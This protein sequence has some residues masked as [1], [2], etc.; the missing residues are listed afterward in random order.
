MNANLTDADARHGRET[1]RAAFRR[2]CGIGFFPAGA[3]CVR[4]AA[5]RPGDGCGDGVESGLCRSRNGCEYGIY[6]TPEA[7]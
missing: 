1:A 4:R 6:V 3:D 2:P 5:F 7:V